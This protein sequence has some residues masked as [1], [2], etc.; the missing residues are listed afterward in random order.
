MRKAIALIML[1]SCLDALA[2]ERLRPEFARHADRVREADAPF[3]STPALRAVFGVARTFERLH[4]KRFR[5][6]LLVTLRARMRAD[7]RASSHSNY[8]ARE[9]F[10]DDVT[11]SSP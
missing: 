11:V 8:P 4:P 1:L 7:L 6:R 3:P 9:V 10:F 2:A 5:E